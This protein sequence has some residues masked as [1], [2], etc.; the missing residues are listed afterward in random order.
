[1]IWKFELINSSYSSMLILKMI[2]GNSSYFNENAN[3]IGINE[4]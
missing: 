4:W 3:N 2:D 1:M